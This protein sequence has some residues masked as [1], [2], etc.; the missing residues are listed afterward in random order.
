MF[1]IKQGFHDD[2][3]T[4]TSCVFDILRS[5]STHVSV[6]LWSWAHILDFIPTARGLKTH[7]NWNNILKK[8]IKAITNKACAMWHS[9]LWSKALKS[10]YCFT[11][12]SN[13]RP[14]THWIW[15]S[16]CV[17]PSWEF[18]RSCIFSLLFLV[19]H[20]GFFGNPT[21][22]RVYIPIRVYL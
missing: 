17:L 19:F 18:I 2:R 9:L 3:R 12:A 21:F 7:A 5:V 16:T 6:G 10:P 15:A 1:L 20:L 4:F 13:M 14:F 8:H 11:N 22:C